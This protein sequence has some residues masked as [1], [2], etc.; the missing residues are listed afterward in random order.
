MLENLAVVFEILMVV[1]FGFSW[2][3]N[4]IKSY[5]ARTAKGTSLYFTLLIAIGY[6]GG[7]L[8]KILAAAQAAQDGVAYWDWLKILA[9]VFYFINLIM[10]STGI[11]IYF[12]NKKLDKI[13]AKKEAENQ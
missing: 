9:F 1:C 6:V 8:S 4:I 13:A 11:A 3:F 7:I 12:R 10:V 5:K 2:P